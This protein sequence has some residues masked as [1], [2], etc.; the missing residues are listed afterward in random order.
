LTFLYTLKWDME[1]IFALQWTG[2]FWILLWKT[3]H[4]E[5]ALGPSRFTLQRVNC[6][7]LWVFSECNLLYTDLFHILHTKICVMHQFICFCG[8][9]KIGLNLCVC[10]CVRTGNREWDCL[11]PNYWAILVYGSFTQ[12]RIQIEGPE[13]LHS[14]SANTDCK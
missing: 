4:S 11:E 1:K 3:S 10:V 5:S 8:F 7:Y 6:M 12:E 13:E 2:T 9:V 14:L